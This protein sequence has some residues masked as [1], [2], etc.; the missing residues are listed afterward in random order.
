MRPRWCDFGCELG[1]YIDKISTFDN[2]LQSLDDMKLEFIIAIMVMNVYDGFLFS[3]FSVPLRSLIF[4]HLRLGRW[5]LSQVTASRGPFWVEKNTMASGLWLPWCFMTYW[6]KSWLPS[7]GW[8]AIGSKLQI[9]GS[10]QLQKHQR[11][12]LYELCEI[13]P[14]KT[15]PRANWTSH[16]LNNFGWNPSSA[17]CRQVTAG[18]H[19]VGPKRRVI[20]YQ[21]KEYKSIKKI[22]GRN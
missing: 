2:T 17:R 8:F 7:S 11:W 13:L 4:A 10:Q 16:E 15:H 3:D 20:R 1:Q 14:P 21:V 9:P 12:I 19:V 5:V 18:I 6:N 22:I